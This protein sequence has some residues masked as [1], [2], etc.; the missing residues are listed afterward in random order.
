MQTISLTAVQIKELVSFAKDVLPDESC[1]LLLGQNDRV[2][3]ILP[4]RNADESPITFSIEPTELLRAYGLAES[5][6][7]E[8][9]AIFH[10]HPSRPSPSKTDRIFMEIN[11]IV[12]LIYSTTEQIL[13]AYVYHEDVE[14]VGIK[15]TAME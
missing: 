10:S 5:K 3:E 1:A 4:M 6:G 12:W 13:K 15:I 9:I 8:V 2:L 7:L 14:D 11:P